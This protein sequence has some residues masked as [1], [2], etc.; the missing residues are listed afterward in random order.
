M[1]SPRLAAA[2]VKA[3]EICPYM[4]AALWRLRLVEVPAADW[5]R[6]V[7]PAALGDIGTTERGVV[8]VSGGL[9]AK[10]S[11]VDLAADLVHECMH[12]MLHHHARRGD[13]EPVTWNMGADLSYAEDI[14]NMVD[15]KFDPQKGNPNDRYPFRNFRGIRAHQF[16]F[17]TGETA[18]QYYERLQARQKKQGLP[19]GCACGT[20]AGNR[21][22]VEGL[23]QVEAASADA[24]APIEWDTV[25]LAVAAAVRQH[26]KTKGRGSAPFGIER[27]AE[28]AFEPSPVDWRR[29]LAAAVR[30]ELRAAGAWDYTWTRP[31]RRGASGGVLLPSL[32]APR[33]R[34]AVLIDTSGSRSERD[35]ELDLAD[36]RGILKATGAEVQVVTCDAAVQGRG[37]VVSVAQAARMLVGGG[38]SDFR[39]AFEALLEG[40]ERPEVVIA[41][42]DADICWPESFPVR[43]V[44]VVPEGAREMPAWI[45]RIEKAAQ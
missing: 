16:H 40:R 7:G 43:T 36:V 24:P 12:I 32:R 45:V 8:F 29:A 2:R 26:V 44:A 34:A 15:D 33:V 42:T 37:R 13:R 39:P 4:T 23:E 3:S 11:T 41:M 21:H 25:R 28:A 20:A 6:A 9:V 35:L 18:E 30:A 1:T 17:P 10:S 19:A 27:W 22:P 5:A 14:V 31:S 38:G